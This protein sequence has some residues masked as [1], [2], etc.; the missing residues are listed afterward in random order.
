[1]PDERIYTI[2]LIKAKSVPRPRRANRAVKE[3]RQFLRRHMKAEEVYVDASLNEKVWERGRAHIPTRIRVKGV[4]GDDGVVW[5]YTPE[6]EVI[7]PEERKLR[8][9]EEEEAEVEAPPTPVEELEE[10][11]EVSAEGEEPPQEEAEE[12]REQTGEAREEEAESEETGETEVE[13]VEEGAPE[14]EEETEIHP[15]EAEPGQVAVEE[16]EVSAQSEKGAS[17]KKPQQSGGT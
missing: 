4:K 15:E 16:A 9:E 13:E 12:L 6:A 2:P 5:A 3:I 14:A 17:S 8:R 11:A 10:E 7:S 1:M